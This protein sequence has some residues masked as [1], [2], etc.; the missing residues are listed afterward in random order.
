MNF[1]NTHKPSST[2]ILNFTKILTGYFILNCPLLPKVKKT[3][4]LFNSTFTEKATQVLYTEH[5]FVHQL[6]P[7]ST[8]L[9]FLSLRN[10]YTY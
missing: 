1:S 8:Q 3:E 10:L 9:L 5:W 4:S 7:L 2:A 6:Y